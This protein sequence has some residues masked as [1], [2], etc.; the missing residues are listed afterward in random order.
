MI[1]KECYVSSNGISCIT[2]INTLHNY[3]KNTPLFFFKEKIIYYL[4]FRCIE[5]VFTDFYKN[6][7]NLNFS[8]DKYLLTAISLS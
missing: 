7:N 5:F 2:S 3:K 1:F 4:L 8:N 6:F